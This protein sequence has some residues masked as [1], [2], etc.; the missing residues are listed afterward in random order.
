M[1]FTIQCECGESMQVSEGAAGS[2]RECRCGRT[3]QVPSSTQL[4]VLAGLPAQPPN[5]LADIPLMVAEGALPSL[6][7]CARCNVE[8]ADSA[9][10]I[11][12]C[13][14]HDSSG[15]G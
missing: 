3:V 13:E 5:P 10:A 1:Q 4:R 9:V 12:D 15:E 8:T 7:T 6:T 11:V 2:S 14:I